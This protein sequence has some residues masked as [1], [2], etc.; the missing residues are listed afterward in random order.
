MSPA[1]LLELSLGFVDMFTAAGI[2]RS[3]GLSGLGGSDGSTGLAG[4][5]TGAAGAGRDWKTHGQQ[6]C[7]LGLQLI[8]IFMIT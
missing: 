6:M 3:A 7:T 4:G 2:P 8:I 5:P 1:S